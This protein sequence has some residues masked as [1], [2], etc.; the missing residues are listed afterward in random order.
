M[1]GCQPRWE[2]AQLVD[3]FGECVQKMAEAANREL[4]T[5]VVPAT[6]EMLYVWE[7]AK[8]KAASNELDYHF[9]VPEQY[10]VQSY[11]GQVMNYLFASTS[12]KGVSMNM[13]PWCVKMGMYI[14]DYLISK[15]RMHLPVMR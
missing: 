14:H 12:A 6:N 1:A 5:G 7:K 15:E 8:I 4:Y 13:V 2:G 10:H 11:W 3:G 9:G